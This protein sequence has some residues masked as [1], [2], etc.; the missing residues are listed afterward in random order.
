MEA[1]DLIDLKAFS[2]LM[3]ANETLKLKWLNQM[4]S[5]GNIL[6]AFVLDHQV[7]EVCDLEMVSNKFGLRNN[8]F[9]CTVPLHG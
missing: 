3:Q 8:N 2:K 4:E 6:F 1:K 5:I 9:R 7:D